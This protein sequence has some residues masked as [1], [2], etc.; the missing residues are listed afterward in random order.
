MNFKPLA[1]AAAL[2]A[3]GTAQATCYSVY[4]ADGTIIQE[5]SVTPVDLSLPIGDTVVAKF[6]PGTSMTISETGFYCKDRGVPVVGRPQSLAEVVQAEEEKMVIKAPAATVAV[7]LAKAQSPRKTAAKQAA[8]DAEAAKEDASKAA[9]LKEDSPK[10]ATLREDGAKT[11]AVK[12]DSSKTVMVKD[13][14][15]QTVVETRQGTVLKVKPK[16]KEAQ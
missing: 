15:T 16:K 1:I 11:V 6:G 14:G 5:T 10:A 2:L 13:D 7:A 8:P 12:E 4:K 9:T 3:A